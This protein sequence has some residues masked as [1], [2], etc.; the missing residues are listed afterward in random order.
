MHTNKHTHTCITH[1]H[2]CTHAPT[3]THAHMHARTPPPPPHT[4][5]HTKEGSWSWQCFLCA[6]LSRTPIDQLEVIDYEPEYET[7]GLSWRRVEVPSFDN[8]EEPLLY[9]IECQDSQSEAWRP[10]VSGVPTTRYRIP[11]IGPTDDYSFRVR[12]L[13]PYGLSPPSHP[14][15]LYRSTSEDASVFL[16]YPFYAFVFVCLSV[17]FLSL[18]F[19]LYLSLSLS[20]SHSLSLSVSLSLSLS[21]FLSPSLSLSIY[22][23]FATIICISVCCNAC[24]RVTWSGIDL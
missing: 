12:A 5:T 17:F 24:C 21:V 6:A 7:V 16:F 18:C 8:E 11:D 3:H 1:A 13:T 14:T 23:Y 10:L 15:G 2:T 9:M 4:H 19:C 22:I 20:L